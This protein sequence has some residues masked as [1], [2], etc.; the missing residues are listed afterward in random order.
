MPS[1]DVIETFM[2][3]RKSFEG[4]LVRNGLADT[5]EELQA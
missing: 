2:L 1:V 5:P 3:M 4:A